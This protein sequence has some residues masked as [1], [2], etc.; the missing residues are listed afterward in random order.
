MLL[1]V[2]PESGDVV[3]ACSAVPTAIPGHLCHDGYLLDL[4]D[5]HL[6]G[7]V[8]GHSLPPC[9][10]RSESGSQTR[11]VFYNKNT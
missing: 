9:G 11:T 3:M 1:A 7:R 6:A 5:S 4:A 8:G 10:V 2:D